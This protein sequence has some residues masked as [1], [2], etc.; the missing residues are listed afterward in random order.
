MSSPT[1]SPAVD[2]R[3]LAHLARLELTEQEI[4]LFE[5]Q[6]NQILAYMDQLKQLDVSGIEPTAHAV[7]RVN[8]MRPDE[9]QPGLT[10]E[11][12]LSNAPAKMDGLFLVPK[13]VE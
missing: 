4:A 5:A 11:E 7:P 8:V 13:I 1:A 10:Q 12:A 2:V 9:M 3:Y 6:L